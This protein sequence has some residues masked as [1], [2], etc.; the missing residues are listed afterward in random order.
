[1][2]PGT[3]RPARLPAVPGRCRER[4]RRS[5]R[6]WRKRGRAGEGSWR[7]SGSRVGTVRGMHTSTVRETTVRRTR[8][9][10]AIDTRCPYCGEPLELFVDGSAGDQ[11]Y[12]EDCQVCCRPIVVTVA[13]DADGEPVVA[14]RAEDEARGATAAARGWRSV[15]PAPAAPVKGVF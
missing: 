8:M 14:V 4:C 12:I 10:P 9:L 2:R 11:Q 13:L 15:A 7:R 5:G 3:G 6:G 1:M